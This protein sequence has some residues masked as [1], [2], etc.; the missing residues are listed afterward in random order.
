MP[1]RLLLKSYFRLRQ[2]YFFQVACTMRTNFWRAQGMQIGHNVRFS[3]L[4]VTWPHKVALGDSCSLEH[5][6]Y[7]NAAGPY[8]EGV[9]IAIGEGCFIGTGC[10]FNITSGLRIGRDSLIAAG[11]R[12]IDHN[13]GTL[14]DVP[15]KHQPET[16]APITIG[17]DVWIG[18][19]SVILQGVT[20]GNGAIVAAGSVVT[21]SVPPFTVVAGCPARPKRDRRDHR[22][23]GAQLLE[24]LSKTGRAIPLAESL[25]AARSREGA[26]T[27]SV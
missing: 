13:H 7:L 24:S 21:R 22:T 27:A 10:E 25:A 5:G 11:T 20:I 8:S 6:T 19:N 2:R 17:D 14:C 23:V 1:P 16:A 15:M 26:L 18:V 3:R 4:E 12:I 9:S